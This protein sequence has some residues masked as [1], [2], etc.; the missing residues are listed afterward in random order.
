MICLNS[1]QSYS[2]F[3]SLTNILVFFAIYFLSVIV[4]VAFF[5]LLIRRI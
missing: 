4:V 1:G 2:F 3:S 5:S